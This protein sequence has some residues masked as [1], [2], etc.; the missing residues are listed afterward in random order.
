[1]KIENADKG[2][3][4]F[5]YD[6]DLSFNISQRIGANDPIKPD[7]HSDKKMQDEVVRRFNMHEK[8]AEAIARNLVAWDTSKDKTIGL[9]PEVYLRNQ[10]LYKDLTGE[11]YTFRRAC[12]RFNIRD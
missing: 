11:E 3:G 6:Y 1:M 9:L 8:L 10:S 12:K 5:E 4:S 2:N 7:V